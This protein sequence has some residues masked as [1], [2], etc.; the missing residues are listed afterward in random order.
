MLSSFF[1]AYFVHVLCCSKQVFQTEIFTKKGLKLELFLQKKQKFFLRFILRPPSKVTNLTPHPWPPFFENFSL[2][3]LNS[4]QRASVKKLVN[5]AD[6]KPV[7][8]PVNR[9]KLEV[10]R[11]GRE[12]PSRFHFCPEFR[13]ESFLSSPTSL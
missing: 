2:D 3:A 12:N 9:R 7:D 11:S 4:E 1:H 8:R 6:Q 5:R 10:Y 13:C